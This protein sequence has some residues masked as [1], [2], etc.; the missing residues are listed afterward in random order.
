MRLRRRG[1]PVSAWER[2]IRDDRIWQAVA[3]IPPGKVSTYG[4]VARAA[5]IPRGAR[6]VGRALRACPPQLDLPWHRVLGA[7]GRIALRGVRGQEQ[8]L[9]LEFEDVPFSGSRV[10]LDL[11]RWRFP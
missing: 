6:L 9:R 4:D 2:S 8:R 1:A 5:G 7:G 11:C 10:R 3:S